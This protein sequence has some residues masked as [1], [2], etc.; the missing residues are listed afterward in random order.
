[1]VRRAGGDVGLGSGQD[2]P[3][4]TL[5]LVSAA[6]GAAMGAAST[7]ADRFPARFFQ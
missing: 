5:F 7:S 6:M 2:E 1:M 3:G 4:W